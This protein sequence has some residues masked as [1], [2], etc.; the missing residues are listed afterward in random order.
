MGADNFS[1]KPFLKWAGGKT[2][3]LESIMDRLPEDVKPPKNSNDK[4]VINS[5]FE[6]F[7]GGGAVF[8]CLSNHYDIKHAYLGD[9][10][11]DLILTYNII[12]YKAQDLIEKLEGLS[13][14]YKDERNSSEDRKSMFY[15]KKDKFNE[16]HNKIDTY[17]LS[18]KNINVAALM[19]FLNKT[20]FNGLYRVN[21]NNEFNVP[22]ANPKNPL[23]CDKENIIEVSNTLT[24]VELFVGDYSKSI[25]GMKNDSLVYFDPPYRPINGKK[26]FEGYSKS[27]FN[28]KNQEE[29]AKFCREID[30]KNVRFI[31][32]NS[33]PHNFDETDNFFDDLY[34]GFNIKRV[35]AKRFINS[36]GNKRGP[37][38]EILVSNY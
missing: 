13:D 8:F 33:D 17:G 18:K 6:P 14:E 31:L 32:S 25:V 11:K 37:I 19:I 10:N 21:K 27:N 23:I 29:L 3:L 5:Y 34:D 28:D 7:V 22:F 20:C 38:T 2:Q 35:S 30:K 16:I 9:T 1:P 24:G 4:G 12:K 26:S 15:E 36:N